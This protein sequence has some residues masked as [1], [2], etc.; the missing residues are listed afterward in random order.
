MRILIL[1][2]LFCCIY[3]NSYA[4]QKSGRPKIGLTL[5]GGGAKGIAHIGILKA[6]DSAGI[7]VDYIT[8]TSMGSIVGALYAVGYSGKDIEKIANEIDWGI[9][10]TNQ[11][12][13]DGIIMEEKDE[14]GRYAI[15]L[16]YSNHRFRLYTGVLEAEELWLKFSELFYPVYNVKSF[17]KFS[18]PFKCVA[19]NAANGEMVLL[20]KGEIVNAI[21]SSMAIPSFFTAVEI[22]SLKLVD[23]GVVRNFPVTDVREM[24]ADYV[25]GVNVSDGLLPAEK[26]NN[27]ISVLMNIVFFKEAE[28][29]KKEIPLCDIYI[30]MPVND[31]SAAS[32]AKSTE[33]MDTGLNV[34]K[35]YYPL[36]KK[37][38]DS[39]DAIYGPQEFN[40]S[41]LP[42]TDS[43]F[44]READVKGLKYTDESFFFH[45]MG[46]QTGRYYKSAEIS[47]RIRKG[48]G[49]RYY[50][51]ITYNLDTLADGT[52]KIHFSAS[53]NAL[54]AAKFSVH[55]NK[56]TGIAVVAN[57]TIRNL[58]TNSSRSLIT[59]N[60]GERFRVRAEHMEYV[61]KRR[62][63]SFVLGTQY[64]FLDFNSYNKFEQTDI[65]RQSYFKADLRINYSTNRRFTAGIGTRYETL[66]YKPGLKADFNAGGKNNFLT[67]YAELKWNTLDRNIYPR[68]GFKLD[69]GG[70]IVY[71][72]DG[73]IIYYE[74]GN[75]IFNTDSL[76]LS[77]DPYARFLLNL[78]TYKQ[79][80]RKGTFFTLLQSGMNFN[81]NVYFLNDFFVGGLNRL[82]RNQVL[83]AGY[84][85]GT[86]N[87]GSIAALQLGYR[88]QVYTNF[89]LSLR[90]NAMLYGFIKKNE[91]FKT[92][93][94]LSGHSL[95]L[96]YLTAIGPVEFSV[97]YG[98][99][100]G[101]LK[102]YVNIGLPF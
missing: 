74:N 58:L 44:I 73:N 48:F 67:S 9:L 72:Q 71:N 43:I 85:E 32:F 41:R 51:R 42:T 17:D 101:K 66:K 70:E 61:G 79:V 93:K 2:S 46:F 99:Q 50:N 24:G 37:L 26:L 35:R 16:P 25:I 4:Q 29:S 38:K 21:R 59:A 40:P 95:S 81:Y 11:S 96:G 45:M 18:I 54:A 100:S 36:F 39:L 22:D 88:Q 30:P 84:E 47:R 60:L 27:P 90:T 82:F 80:G 91:N 1:F 68:K 92:A 19:T 69:V 52:A 33:I 87:T 76:G 13:L 53:E 34:G 56:F 14:Y 6:L 94:F 8:G 97:M 20:D 7:K 102:T 28:D 63:F 65:Y 23:G 86:I 12:G 89:F 57:F 62:D 83:F 75:P 3:L 5:S 55:Y 64:E 10:L 77:Y 49:L 98:D 31:Y 15:E 78:E